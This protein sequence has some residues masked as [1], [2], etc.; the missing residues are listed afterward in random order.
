VPQRT[1]ILIGNQVFRD[2]S[3]LAPLRGPHNDVA[4]L[5]EIL[6][7]QQRGNFAVRTFLDQPHYEILPVID[8]ILG[9][10]RPGDLVLIYYSGHGKLDRA[11]RVCLAT[12]STRATALQ[13]TSIPALDIKRLVDQSDCDQVVLLLDC[14]YSG[15]LDDLRGADVASEMRVIEDAQGFYILTASTG[16]QAA[17]EEASVS[18]GAVMGKFTHALVDGIETGASDVARKGRIMLSDLRQ[19]LEKVVSGQ[20]PQYF[21]RQAHGDPLISLSPSTAAPLLDPAI[22]IDLEASNWHHRAGAV[23]YLVN[24]LQ[25]GI[26]AARQAARRC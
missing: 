6:G 9:S 13:A 14:C 1:A 23:T 22:V 20:T 16:L 7:D 19:H 12:A 26:P 4:R 8:E 5:S 10:A 2:D 17:R 21:A 25:S 11:G 18:G 15:A 24:T 3:G